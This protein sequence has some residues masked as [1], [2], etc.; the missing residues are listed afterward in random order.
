M[1][2]ADQ[3]WLHS[4]YSRDRCTILA[5]LANSWLM[6]IM[7]LV[8][9]ILHAHNMHTHMQHKSFETSSQSLDIVRG[10]STIL[11]G[12]AEA[13]VLEVLSEEDEAE[14]KENKLYEESPTNVSHESPEAR[15]ALR[16]RKRARME[17]S[18]TRRVKHHRAKRISE[19]SV[20]DNIPQPG[21]PGK[22]PFMNPDLIPPKPTL[23]HSTP[24][25][26]DLSNVPRRDSL[27]GFAYL[28]SPLVLS[29]VPSTSYVSDPDGS[30]GSPEHRQSPEDVRKPSSTQRWIGTYDIPIRK[31]T[32][33][34]KKRNAKANNKRVS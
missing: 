13:K 30:G 26:L 15:P 21:K 27:F 5:K 7:G 18:P 12:P 25:E 16:R 4:I 11:N 1:G 33:K 28:E 10:N 2:L 22:H 32:P 17:N 34:N 8:M 23:G 24:G 14:G 31:P 20:K 9:M 19:A 29:P 3:T 6:H